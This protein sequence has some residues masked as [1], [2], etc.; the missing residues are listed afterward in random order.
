MMKRL[1]L[2]VGCLVFGHEV[3][4]VTT[5]SYQEFEKWLEGKHLVTVKGLGGDLSISGEVRVE[6]QKKS[7]VINNVQ[8]RGDAG[9]V[10]RSPKNNY[11]VELNLMFN[12]STD[13]SWANVKIEM[14]NNAG[15]FNGT[16][17]RINLERA[18]FGVK[19]YK[20][21]VSTGSL[22]FGRRGL[23]NVF[24]SQVEFGSRMDGFLLNVTAAAGFAGDFYLTTGPFLVNERLDQYAYVG[25][26]GVLNVC[27]TGVYLKYSLI[28]W[29]TKDFNSFQTEHEYLFMNSQMTL[30]YKFVS[31]WIKKFVTLYTAGLLNHRAEGN[32]LT[33]GKRANWAWY[34]GFSF[35]EAIKTGDW[36]LNINYQEVAAQAIPQ[37]D[38]GGIGTG[39]TAGA[40]FY[41][42]SSSR[43]AF[44]ETNFKGFM[45]DLLYLFSNNLTLQQS[46]NQ[47]IRLDHSIGPVFRN[48]QYEMEL[49]YSF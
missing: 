9:A 30:G 19:L 26:I 31:P 25:E 20:H 14:D 38:V 10:P 4:A 49:I 18:I 17:G 33:N 13:W 37:F 16:S 1:L 8:Q 39:N 3:P 42:A 40:N 15:V 21:D 12:Y 44:G 43:T 7:E 36:S 32:F 34:A 48:K 11:D 24:D 27:N 5:P 41:A 23:S 29:D 2:L 6:Y 46:Y 35:G 28:D 47:S 45:I 22:I